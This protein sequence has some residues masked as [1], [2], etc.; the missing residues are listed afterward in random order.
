MSGRDLPGH[1]L[2]SIFLGQAV[3]QSLLL[4][5]PGRH[6]LTSVRDHRQ[7]E[8]EEETPEDDDPECLPVGE[9]GK[10][11]EILAE[12]IPPT[13]NDRGAEQEAHQEEGDGFEPHPSQIGEG[14][15]PPDIGHGERRHASQGNGRIREDL[16]QATQGHEQAMG[17]RRPTNLLS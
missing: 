4:P 15:R 5:G 9:P 16:S 8:Y 1:G 3:G 7:H 12:R 10:S 2:R 6:Q 11:T 13:L 14:K 17:H